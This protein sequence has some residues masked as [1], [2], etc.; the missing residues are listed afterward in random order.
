MAVEGKKEYELAYL[1]EDEARVSAPKELVRAAG[2]E[3]RN[4]GQASRIRLAY[5]VKHQTE[6]FFGFLQFMLE[7][8]G[9]K[10]LEKSLNA[11]NRIL[12]SLIITP[13]P[14]KETRRPSE[15]PAEGRPPR[16]QESRPMPLSN[17]ALEKKIEEI[18]Q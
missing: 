17:E 14:M 11:D 18:L 15:A 9:A 16:P 8:A 5:P 13:P 3:I 10:E 12:R 4:E 2:G 1:V 6:A 7:P